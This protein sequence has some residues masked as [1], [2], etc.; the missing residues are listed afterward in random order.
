MADASKFAV[1]GLWRAWANEAG[2]TTHGFTQLT[3][4]AD[5]YELMK[6]FH[7]PGHEKSSLVIVPVDDYDAWLDCRDPELARSFLR[8]YPAELM[9]AAPVPKAPRKAAETGKE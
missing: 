6:H 7:K 2:A 1:A 3:L 5:E 8:L 9:V 4:Y